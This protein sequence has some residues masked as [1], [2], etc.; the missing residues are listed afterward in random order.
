M[1][2]KD[3]PAAFPGAQ[4]ASVEKDELDTAALVR[5]AMKSMPR[6][7]LAPVGHLL[8][9]DTTKLAEQLG[10]PPSEAELAEA[11]L[12]VLQG[13]LKGRLGRDPTRTELSNARDELKRTPE[14]NR[15]MREELSAKTYK[16]QK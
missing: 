13:H 8:Y 1:A 2:P 5:E 3:V 16:P 9:V 4:A 6:E 15:V 10:R 12:R 11:H 7:G 14:Y